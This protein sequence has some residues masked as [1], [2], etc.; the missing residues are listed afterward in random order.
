MELC[1]LKYAGRKYRVS[2]VS[3]KRARQTGKRGAK[4]YSV[5]CGAFKRDAGTGRMAFQGL[6]LEGDVPLV[7]LVRWARRKGFLKWH[8][9]GGRK[10]VRNAERRSAGSVPAAPGGGSQRKVAG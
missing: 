1:T 2:L 4:S 6:A 7:E 9:E 3:L 10:N 5:T 8:R